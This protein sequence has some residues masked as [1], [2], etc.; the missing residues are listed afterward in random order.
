MKGNEISAKQLNADAAGWLAKL[1][2]T[3]LIKDYGKG[4]VRNYTQ[5]MCLLFKYYNHKAVAD[6]KQADIEQY[7][8]YIKEVHKV[9]RAK[10]RSVA[11][12]CSFF[13]KRILPAPYIVPS[14]LYPKKQFILPNI[15]TEE[16]VVQLFAAPLNVKE[17][18]VTGLLYGCG[19]RISE[20]C[21]LRL[22]DIESHN[23]RLKVYQGKGAKDRYTLLPAKLLTQLRLLYVQ[24]GRPKQ[25]LFTSKQ[26]KRAMHV[27][28]MQL[29][30]NNAMAKAGFKEKPFTAHTLR[31]SFA[32]HMLNCGNNIHVI[33]TLLGHSKLETTMVYLHL[34]KHTQAGI[35]SPLDAVVYGAAAK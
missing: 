30:V 4:S 3:M 25:Y 17:Y 13:F 22:Q 5:E 27:R 23:Q 21:L 24:E 34:Q 2:Q 18:C 9:G 12:A 31:H 29:V 19:L 11:Q 1:H 32:T 7:M 8:Q 35:V 10:C 26:T 15:M 20:V 33:K 28:S 6:I 16:Q 14:N